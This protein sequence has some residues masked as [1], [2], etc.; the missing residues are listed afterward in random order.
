M[1][2]DAAVQSSARS[3]ESR[4]RVVIAAN[5]LSATVTI[6]K[7]LPEERSITVE[8]INKVLAEAKVT[9]GID[10][11]AI[12]QGVA[13][14]EFDVPFKVATGIMAKKGRD[15]HIEILCDIDQHRS[16]K[17][18]ED[19]RIDYHDMN[20]ILSVEAGTAL[21]RKTPAAEGVPGTGVDGK[22]IPAQMGRDFPF[23]YGDNV[24][25]SEDGLE[26]VAK[27]SGGISYRHGKVSV[28]DVVS[29]PGNVDFSVGNL[30]CIGSVRVHGNIQAG[31]TVKVG[32]DLEVNGNVEDA[33]I[34]VKG[35]ILIKG[36]CFGKGAKVIHADGDVTLKYAEGQRITSGRNIIVG[37]EL[38]NC[39]VTAKEK[40]LVKGKNGKIIGGE[41]NAGKEI[42]AVSFGSDAGTITRLTV[43]FDANLLEQYRETSA[44]I[45]RLNSDNDRV[46]ESLYAL[47]RIQMDGDLPPA[48]KQVLEKLEEFQKS[49]PDVLATLEKKK[50]VIE[51]KLKQY[52]DAQIVVE[53]EMYPG[54]TAY[55]GIVYRSFD[56][57]IGNCRLVLDDDQVVTSEIREDKN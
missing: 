32:G 40:V 51:E 49:V 24:V 34:D 10:E 15:A 50:A 35:N 9:F 17:V 5:R 19:G 13:S 48:K 38:I 39:Q 4:V 21:A 43:A 46:K 27:V 55:F 18:G 31:F 57:N 30:D 12:V 36:G 16:P 6:R 11:E 42:R 2:D 22:S 56:E 8:D 52:Q 20:T 44:E 37:G 33:E 29:I 14:R 7:P 41:T 45:E 28:N 3:I 47:Y 26:L 53:G 54:V 25:V 23:K 1:T